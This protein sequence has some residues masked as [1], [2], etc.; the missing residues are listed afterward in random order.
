MTNISYSWTL[1]LLLITLNSPMINPNPY[2]KCR[3]G[4]TS[5]EKNFLRNVC[6][7]ETEIMIDRTKYP[8]EGSRKPQWTKLSP[9]EIGIKVVN[10][11]GTK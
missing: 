3:I 11:E 10:N 6:W 4:K 8:R 7:I 9:N 5:K 1:L 2:P